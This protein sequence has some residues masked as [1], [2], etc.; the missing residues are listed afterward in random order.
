MKIESAQKNLEETIK[1]LQ[2]K[3]QR[4]Q[5]IKIIKEYI[6]NER[7]IQEQQ[8]K[9]LIL[10]EIQYSPI[11][12]CY[13]NKPAIENGIYL[14]GIQRISLSMI[15]ARMFI[16]KYQANMTYY[17]V[18]TLEELEKYS[19]IVH[20]KLTE[21][22]YYEDDPI[23]EEESKLLQIKI[24]KNPKNNISYIFK[25]NK[26][27]KRILQEELERDS[28][29]ISKS[30]STNCFKTGHILLKSEVPIEI[31]METYNLEKVSSRI[32]TALSDS[33]SLKAINLEKRSQVKKVYH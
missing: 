13:Y 26:E 2:E 10:S 19:E 23:N 1:I 18:V 32:R 12:N 27:S 9:A 24:Y 31:L 11:A 7:Q 3:K 14:N 5:S 16:E 17:Y 15:L 29:D 6:E 4:L 25:N 33:Q 20:Q 28:H 22:K 21:E 8:K 30:I